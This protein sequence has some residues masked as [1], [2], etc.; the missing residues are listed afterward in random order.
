MARTQGRALVTGA[1]SPTSALIYGIALGVIGVAV[2]ALG[3]N[4]LT[5]WIEVA[6]FVLYVAVYGLFKRRGPAGVL[7]GSLPG[8]AP[9]LAGYAAATGRLDL[10]A[11]LLFVILAAWQMPHFYAIALYRAEEYRAAGIPVLPVAKGVRR[12]RI[13][14]L[15]YTVIFFISLEPAHYFRLC[16]LRV[17][18]AVVG[19]LSIGWLYFAVRGFAIPD[20]R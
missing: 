18:L 12:T 6:G 7:V 15:V 1:I 16:R 2:L 9:I 17:S 3:T 8:A 13:E 11:L 14:I 19:L 10:A 20:R 4:A 5:A